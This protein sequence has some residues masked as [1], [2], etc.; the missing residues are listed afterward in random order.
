MLAAEVWDVWITRV[1]R[2]GWTADRGVRH[3]VLGLF[4]LLLFRFLPRF[5]HIFPSFSS[6]L[7]FPLFQLSPLL[8]PLPPPLLSS[9]ITTD[10]YFSHFPFPLK[11]CRQGSSRQLYISE[12]HN[13]VSYNFDTHLSLRACM[14]WKV[15][16]PSVMAG[17]ACHGPAENGGGVQVAGQVQGV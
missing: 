11:F 9:S 8:F 2:T 13:P 5:L 17:V 6:F 3:S 15:C 14:P 7:S 12:V 16:A 4:A 10:H 1:S